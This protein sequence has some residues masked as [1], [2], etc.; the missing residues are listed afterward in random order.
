ML[1]QNKLG[2]RQLRNYAGIKASKAF[3]RSEFPQE[4]ELERKD[5]MY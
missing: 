3:H 1:K 2:C 4:E 5:K